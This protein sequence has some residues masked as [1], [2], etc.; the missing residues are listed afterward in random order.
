MALVNLI[1]GGLHGYAGYRNYWF[2]NRML[3]IV[4][5]A[6]GLAT[7]L[8]C[9]CMPTA[10]VLAVYGLIVYLNG[11]VTAAFQMVQQGHPADTV[12]AVFNQYGG[13]A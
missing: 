13:Q 1:A 3:G 5:L 12:I 6:G 10:L 11:P 7:V 2:K 8:G 4:A 9:Y